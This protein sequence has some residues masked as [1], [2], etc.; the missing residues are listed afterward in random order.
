MGAG[1]PS[2][3]K[4]RPQP[5][6]SPSECC[7][8]TVQ[9]WT[10]TID[11]LNGRFSVF[12]YQWFLHRSNKKCCFII[13]LLWCLCIWLCRLLECWLTWV[14][15]NQLWERRK[16]KNN[17]SLEGWRCDQPRLWCSVKGHVGNY[18][19]FDITTDIK[20][21]VK[22]SILQ[23]DVIYVQKELKLKWAEI[24]LDFVFE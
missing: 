6:Q 4:I 12:S 22:R 9:M 21:N 10:R 16:W 18:R 14:R 13:R 15:S 7:T 17:F 5:A 3:L 8:H 23:Q 24:C 11:G 20:D 1:P 2:G 19:R